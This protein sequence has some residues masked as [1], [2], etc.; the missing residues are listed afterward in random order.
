MIML[1]SVCIS[2]SEVRMLKCLSSCD[3]SGWLILEHFSKQVHSLIIDLIRGNDI[4]QVV[5][6]EIRP[7]DRVEF[8]VLGQAG[9][10][11]LSRTPKQ[12]KDLLKLRN[13]PLSFEQG[14]VNGELGKDASNWPDI[15]RGSILVHFKKELR[16]AIVQSDYTFCVGFDWDREGTGQAKIS[17]LY[18]IV[19]LTGQ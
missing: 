9:P 13:L 15:Y 3:S 5:L 10:W 16:A 1:K 6:G 17:Q 12:S 14:L 4:T 2:I 8:L 7:L 19:L 11:L 18:L